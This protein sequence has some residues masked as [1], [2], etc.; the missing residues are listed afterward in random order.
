MSHSPAQLFS[1]CEL[2]NVEIS[3]KDL[4]KPIMTEEGQCYTYNILT[5]EELFRKKMYLKYFLNIWKNSFSQLTHIKHISGYTTD[6]IH[7]N[8]EKNHQDG[9]SIQVILRMY[10]SKHI[11]KEESLSIYRIKPVKF[12]ILIHTS[13]FR[14]LE[15]KQAW[16][17]PWQWKW[18]TWII[19]VPAILQD[20]RWNT[21]TTMYFWNHSWIYF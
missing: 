17:L 18:L 7:S 21:T 5:A 16:L 15:S 8:M 1:Y 19:C 3:C 13:F 4:F 2:K 12:E 14:F 20:L 10:Q 11:L 6:W 9:I